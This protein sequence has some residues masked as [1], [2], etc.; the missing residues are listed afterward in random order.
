MQQAKTCTFMD[1]EIRTMVDFDNPDD[2]VPGDPDRYVV[3]GFAERNHS[4]ERLSYRSNEP[5]VF[6]TGHFTDARLAARY[7]GEARMELEQ[8]ISRRVIT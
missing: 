1:W 4:S 2:W 5:Q 7:H 8:A 3:R 6:T